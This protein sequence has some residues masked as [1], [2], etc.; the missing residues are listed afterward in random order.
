MKVLNLLFV[1]SLMVVS[2][3][4]S[5]VAEL[6]DPG[7]EIDDR[8]ALVVTDPQNDFLSPKGV[9]WGVVGESVTENKTVPNIESLLKTAK[10]T[11]IPVFVSPHYYYP[12]DKG[13]MFEGALEVL[14][15][16]IKMFDRTGP[17]SLEGFEGS[18]ADFL[19]P[20]K[21]YINDGKTVVTSPHKVYGPEANDLVLQLRKRKVDK[22]ILAGMSA[23]LC[24]EAHMRELLEQGFEVTVVTDG[25]AAAKVPEGD[26]YKAAMVNFRFM[27]NDLW[28]TKEATEKM[29]VF[30]KGK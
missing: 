11:N 12:T 29:K 4:V 23:N 14:M 8:T 24:V 21:K 27:A 26:G 25:T 30:A 1:I 5:A 10:A 19:D 20:Y 13:W 7:M 9:T 6:P 17:L 3:S 18:G 2:Y 16:N 22:V 28:S 15:H